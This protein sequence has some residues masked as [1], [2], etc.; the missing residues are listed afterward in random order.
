MDM[1]RINIGSAIIMG[2]LN[3]IATMVDERIE[4]IGLRKRIRL[5]CAHLG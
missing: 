3:E 5:G 1:A 2:N 4:R